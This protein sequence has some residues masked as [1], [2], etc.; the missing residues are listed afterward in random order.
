MDALWSHLTPQDWIA[1]GLI[2][3]VPVLMVVAIYLIRS[4]VKQVSRHASVTPP[5][6]GSPPLQL[7]T[8]DVQREQWHMGKQ[9]HPRAIID[10]ADDIETRLKRVKAESWLEATSHPHL[11]RRQG[12]AGKPIGSTLVCLHQGRVIASSR[13]HL[14]ELLPSVDSAATTAP[15]GT[16]RAAARAHRREPPWRPACRRRRRP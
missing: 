2:G 7:K 5:R 4:E 6:S 8:T 15:A 12:S 9:R 1:L 13:D 14:T 10:L 11:R 16:T 3:S